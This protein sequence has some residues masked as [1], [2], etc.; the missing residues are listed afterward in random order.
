[1]DQIAA[2][3]TYGR[4]PP[5]AAAIWLMAVRPFSLSLSLTPVAAGASLAWAE[6]GKV[7]WAA[8]IVAALASALIQIGTNLYNDAADHQNGAH[9]PGRAGPLNVI[10]RGLLSA[11]ALARAAWASFA[12]AGLLGLYL[13]YLGGWPILVLGILSIV[14]G[15]AYTGGP[16]PIAYTPLG[17]LFVIA[18]FGLGAVGGTYWLCTGTLG[19]SAVFGGLAL[20]SF[21][22][23]VLMVNNYRDVEEDR[24]LG[25]FTLAIAG[26]SRASRALY[27]FMMA[28]PFGLLVPLAR[29]LP[30]THVWVAA[31]AA[32]LAVVLAVR[33]YREPP[34]SGLTRLLIKT[35][36]TQT[37]FTALLCLGAVL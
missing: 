24:R 14:C 22:A 28:A 18:F 12:G 16:L 27:A 35:A 30:Q 21:A 9:G 31:A 26:G 34:G 32:P 2:R 10:A 23:A 8:V 37:F 4:E 29:L 25:R 6:T 36:R 15:W 5:S 20:G 13:V 1:M 11:S 7:Q 3:D 33:L 19:A 17:E